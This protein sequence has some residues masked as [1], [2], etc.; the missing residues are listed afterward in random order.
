MICDDLY[1]Q[2]SNRYPSRTVWIDVSEDG[3]NGCDI[4]YMYE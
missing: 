2:I 4:E 3:E 1:S